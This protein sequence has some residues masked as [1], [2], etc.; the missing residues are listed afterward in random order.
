MQSL[1][2]ELE[3]VEVIPVKRLEH[4]IELAFEPLKKKV[5]DAATLSNNWAADSIV[6]SMKSSYDWT[7]KNE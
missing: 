3:D 5:S 4:V 7:N 6:P 2:H 1:F